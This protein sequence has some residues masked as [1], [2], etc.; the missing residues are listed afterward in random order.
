MRESILSSETRLQCG[1][2]GGER[3]QVIIQGAD[4]SKTMQAVLSESVLG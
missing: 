4:L 2:I 3:D 1:Q